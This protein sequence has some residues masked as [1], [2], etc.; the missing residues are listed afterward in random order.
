M[1]AG[2]TK[3]IYAERKEKKEAQDGHS[4]TQEALEEEPSQEKVIINH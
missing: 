2:K 4:Q 1:L 3:N